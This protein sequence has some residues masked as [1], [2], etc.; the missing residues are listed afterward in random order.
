MVLI[1]LNTLPLSLPLQSILPPL[2]HHHPEHP[3]LSLTSSLWGSRLFF[4]T[5]R[6]STAF[7]IH[8]CHLGTST[9]HKF[10]HTCRN[11][12]IHYF[13]HIYMGQCPAKSPLWYFFK[14]S[15]TSKR[16]VTLALECM[17]NYKFSALKLCDG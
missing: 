7:C 3:P 6:L 1:T 9:H 16:K 14:I 15:R 12:Y 2:P 13:I 17:A 11:M 10:L 4:S 5:I 8:H